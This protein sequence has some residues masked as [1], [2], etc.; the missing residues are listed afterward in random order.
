MPIVYLFQVLE[1]S[2]TTSWLGT[3]T[4]THKKTQEDNGSETQ[5]QTLEVGTEHNPEARESA[6]P[7]TKDTSSFLASPTASQKGVQISL[8]RD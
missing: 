8:F 3:C 1:P 5:I 7:A 4:K 6:L 2:K